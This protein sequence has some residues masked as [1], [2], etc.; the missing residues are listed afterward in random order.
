[1][2]DRMMSLYSNMSTSFPLVPMDKLSYMPMG[3]SLADVK[4]I[5]GPMKLQVFLEVKDRGK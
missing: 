5:L 2:V 3:R 1:M 4:I